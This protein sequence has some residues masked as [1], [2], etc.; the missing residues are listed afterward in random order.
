MVTKTK[1]RTRCDAEEQQDMP[2]EKPAAIPDDK[3][4]KFVRYVPYLFKIDQHPVWNGRYRIN[5]W[6][7]HWED[8]RVCP[9]NRIARSFY[10]QYDQKK[11]EIIDVTY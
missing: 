2:Q 3:L 4:I 5:V 8:G 7:Q 6:T 9:T 10:V 11:G 1:C